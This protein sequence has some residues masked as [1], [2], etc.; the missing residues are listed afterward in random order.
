VSQILRVESGGY[1]G[2][3]NCNFDISGVLKSRKTTFAAMD[4]RLLSFLII[5]VVFLCLATL[6]QSESEDEDDGVVVTEE[7]SINSQMPL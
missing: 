7:V 4:K 3:P 5:G 2:G 6:S 1:Y